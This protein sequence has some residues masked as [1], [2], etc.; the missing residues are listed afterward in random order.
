MSNTALKAREFSV[1]KADEYFAKAGYTKRGGD[2]ILMNDRGQRLSFNLSTGYAMLADVLTILE[3]EARKAGVELQLEVLDSTAGFKKAMEKKHELTLTGFS[4]STSEKYPRYWDFWNGEQA[5]NPD[6]TVKVQTNNLTETNLPELNALTD[7]FRASEKH[8]EKVQL[9]HQIEQIIHD[10]AAY[11]CGVYRP[12][13]RVAYWRWVRWPADFNVRRS[14][15]PFE[16][17]VQWIDPALKEETL[18]AMKDGK[19]FPAE[20]KVFDQYRP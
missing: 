10:H 13:Y 19:T 7:R 6:G 1:A 9:A 15:Y 11:I 8:E 2:G 17:F 12:M 5:Y 16:A 4:G 20:I 18:Q 3:R 14:E